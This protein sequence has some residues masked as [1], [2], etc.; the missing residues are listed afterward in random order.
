ML[1]KSRAGSR[2][3]GMS[4]GVAK[5]NRMFGTNKVAPNGVVSEVHPTEIKPKSDRSEVSEAYRA[6]NSKLVADIEERRRIFEKELKARKKAQRR[7]QFGTGD[8]KLRV[9]C[10]HHRQSKSM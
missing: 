8:G 2:K 7:I 4:A 3:R 10:K 5:F 6:S 9:R 1:A